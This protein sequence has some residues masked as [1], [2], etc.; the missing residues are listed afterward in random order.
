MEK[1]EFKICN[2]KEVNIKDIRVNN[3]NLKDKETEDFEKIKKGIS[4]KGQRLPIV[5]RQKKDISG[6]EIIDGEQR[7]TACQQLGFNKIIIY[8]EGYISDKEA[9]ELSI[10]YQ[11]QVPFNEVSL[12]FLVKELSEIRELELPFNGIEVNNLLKMA[13]LKWNNFNNKI[14]NDLFSNCFF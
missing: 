1:I 11:Q 4:L 2:I 3:F 12:A 6:Y 13:S 8:N 7:F 14:E 5:V 9:K 10:W